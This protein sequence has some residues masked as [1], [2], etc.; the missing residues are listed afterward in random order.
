MPSIAFEVTRL[1][2]ETPVSALRIGTTDISSLQGILRATGLDQRSVDDVRRSF[3]AVVRQ[4]W[5]SR[6]SVSRAEFADIVER[7]VPPRRAREYGDFFGQIF[8]AYDITE[9]GSASLNALL[10]GMLI[11]VGGSKSEKLSFAWEA[12]RLDYQT[13]DDGRLDIGELRSL[14]RAFLTMLTTLA[15]EM[16]SLPAA[17]VAESVDAVV[18]QASAAVFDWI[19]ITSF[20]L[21][22]EAFGEWYAAGGFNDV[23][24]LELINFAKWTQKTALVLPS[25]VKSAKAVPRLRLTRRRQ[26]F[27]VALR[28]TAQLHRDSRIEPEERAALK[29]L[30]LRSSPLVLSAFD[31]LERARD[32][33]WEEGAG[34]DAIDEAEDEFVSRL[35]AAALGV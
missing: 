14:L 29:S 1:F 11:L 12:F 13:E 30:I 5:G 19:P 26:C 27:A 31:A 22:F 15:G 4:P 3:A 9:S 7:L 8:A 24:W 18:V 10:C 21:P 20:S 2:E 23:P 28:A 34:R 17:L 35:H 6:S 16:R 25:A 33:A 32:L